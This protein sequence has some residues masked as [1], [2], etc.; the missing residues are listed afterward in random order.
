MFVRHILK[1]ISIANWVDS[2]AYG[3]Y[4]ASALWTINVNNNKKSPLEYFVLL[5][6]VNSALGVNSHSTTLRTTVL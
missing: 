1:K 3:T 6:D 5:Y 2:A 4:V